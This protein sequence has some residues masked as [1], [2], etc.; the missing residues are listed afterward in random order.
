MDTTHINIDEELLSKYEKVEFPSGVMYGS[1]P[2]LHGTLSWTKRW[3]RPLDQWHIV[4]T[5]WDV[6]NEGYTDSWTSVVPKGKSME[7]TLQMAKIL[8]TA[9]DGRQAEHE[10]DTHSV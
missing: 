6:F 5:V 8:M 10:H 1:I 2:T 9:Q 7:R 3:D 4:V